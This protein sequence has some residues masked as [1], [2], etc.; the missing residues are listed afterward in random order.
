MSAKCAFS[1][2]EKFVEHRDGL[3][4]LAR[5]PR[6]GA[7]ARAVA[8]R[9]WSLLGTNPKYTVYMTACIPLRLFLGLLM[10]RSQE[11]CQR[12]RDPSS[13]FKSNVVLTL[14]PTTAA[15]AANTPAASNW[16]AENFTR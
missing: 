10:G 5:M 9:R 6:S 1:V 4:L 11:F 7:D 12:L 13:L 8:E 3:G 15:N 2:A 16:F 14:T